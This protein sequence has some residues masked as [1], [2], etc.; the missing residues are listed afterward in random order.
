MP[1][2]VRLVIDRQAG[3]KT[4][5]N[6]SALIT[7]VRWPKRANIGAGKLAIEKRMEGQTK[8]GLTVSWPAL[9]PVHTSTSDRVDGRA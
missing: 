9:D 2:V 5:S 3:P 1:A 4:R 8:I 6:L 7:D